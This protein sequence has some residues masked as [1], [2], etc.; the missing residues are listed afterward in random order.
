MAKRKRTPH[1]PPAA[2][3]RRKKARETLEEASG[4]GPSQ[5]PRSRPKKGAKR[6][7]PKEPADPNAVEGPY[8]VE[9]EVILDPDRRIRWGHVHRSARSAALAPL[10]ERSIT[11]SGLSFALDLLVHRP[12]RVIEE[13]QAEEAPAVEEVAATHVEGAPVEEAPPVEEVA[14]T[15]VE[16]ATVQEVTRGEE[17]PG[18]ETTPV[19]E[20]PVGIPIPAE[21]I[22][23]GATQE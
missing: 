4:A 3:G 14:A 6:G 13:A 5:P 19:E 2:A 12:H 7:G 18:Q 9:F 17:P 20:I 1:A 23:L 21:A 16:G 8:M 15:H 11:G 10:R 22:P